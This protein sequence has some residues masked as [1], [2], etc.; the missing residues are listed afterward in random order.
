M[1]TAV[2]VGTMY[3]IADLLTKCHGK[4]SFVRLL[5]LVKVRAEDLA[6]LGGHLGDS[7]NA[8]IRN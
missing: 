5:D 3:N 6:S 4:G 1:L 2:K 8:V 7:C